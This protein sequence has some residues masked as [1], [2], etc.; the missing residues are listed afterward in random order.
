MISRYLGQFPEEADLTPL[1]DI[2]FI[3]L[4]PMEEE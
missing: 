4:V 1:S 2:S 3:P